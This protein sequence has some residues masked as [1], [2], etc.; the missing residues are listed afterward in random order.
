MLRLLFRSV[1]HNPKYL[2]MAQSTAPVE[3]SVSDN[4][5]AGADVELADLN[6]KKTE[7]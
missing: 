5:D 1:Y 3:P 4:L 6:L 2:E 7:K